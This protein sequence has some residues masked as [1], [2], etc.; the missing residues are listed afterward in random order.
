MFIFSQSFYLSCTAVSGSWIKDLFIYF[1][2][3]TSLYSLTDFHECVTWRNLNYANTS[4]YTA[5]IH[6]M[7]TLY[8][9]IH[10]IHAWSRIQ[11]T[12]CSLSLLV[13][14]Q[15][16]CLAIWHLSLI[17]VII[18]NY[19]RSWQIHGAEFWLILLILQ[20]CVALLARFELFQF[21]PLFPL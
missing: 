11:Y 21:C 7:T 10:M 17:A 3:F 9:N 5:V 14:V 12:I 6:Y 18:T 8:Y 1:I 16:L 15:S 19:S 4:I 20:P 2:Y 13:T